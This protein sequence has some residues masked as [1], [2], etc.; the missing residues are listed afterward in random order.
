[1][2]QILQYPDQKLKKFLVHIPVPAAHMSLYH[3][4]AQ[5]SWH[6]SLWGRAIT[7]I[8]ELLWLEN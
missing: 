2:L 8:T 7:K 1:M 6:K 5:L 3:L 4:Q